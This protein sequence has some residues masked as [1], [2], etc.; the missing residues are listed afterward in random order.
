M[1]EVTKQDDRP[2]DAANEVAADPVKRSG[3]GRLVAWLVLFVFAVALAFA[4][5]R[6]LAKTNTDEAPNPNDELIAS[7]S[8]SLD[9]TRDS[10]EML[11]A[12]VGELAGQAASGDRRFQQLED[13]LAAQLAS[14]DSLPGRVASLEG[15]MSSLRGISSGLRDA[16]LLAEA[17]YYMQ[18]GNA[19]LQLGGN[20]ELAM[21]AMQLADE[22]IQQLADPALTEIRRALADEIRALDAIETPDVEGIA[23]TLSSLAS[24][25]EELPLDNELQ[26]PD[27]ESDEID[28]DLSGMDRMLASIRKTASDV[29]SVRR[30]DETVKPLLAPD[31]QYFLRTNL[32]LQFQ[33]ARIALLR[34]NQAVFDQSLD[35]A[36][37]WIRLYFDTGDA[38]VQS[39]M[40][41][42][43]DAR[44]NVLPASLPDI[45][46]SLRL[47][48]EYRV[49]V[50]R[51]AAAATDDAGAAQ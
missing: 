18:I 19:Q 13:R 11:D 25:A 34:G 14:L 3:S 20:P 26:M 10:V 49:R 44:Q 40:Q 2:D 4:G 28:E 6:Y 24:A 43:N 8:A 5:Y 42:V 30:S 50:T 29:V 32:A 21:L 27:A 37:R 9:A 39:T 23:L 17:E 48:R 45:A 46:G 41:A 51:P 38:A 36:S 31:A 22:K 33:A 15:S 1:N 12:R 7:L 16:W 47:L 35:D